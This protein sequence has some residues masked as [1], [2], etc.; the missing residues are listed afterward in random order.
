MRE[1]NERLYTPRE[2]AEKEIM[3]LGRQWQERKA[4][5]LGFYQVGR[6][7]FYAQ[8]HLDTYFAAHEHVTCKSTAQAVAA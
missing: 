8:R 3:S 5:R 4:K 1:I 7:I 6:K 2:L